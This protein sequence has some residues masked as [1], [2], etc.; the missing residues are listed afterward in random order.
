MIHADIGEFFI[1][2]LEKGQR[3]QE[4]KGRVHVVY[5]RSSIKQ[6]VSKDP[7]TEGI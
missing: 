1:E 6:T 2:P 7:D 3:A 5:R 4:E